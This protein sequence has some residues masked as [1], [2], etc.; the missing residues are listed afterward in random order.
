MEKPHSK[1][2]RSQKECSLTSAIPSIVDSENKSPIFNLE[3]INYLQYSIVDL[4]NNFPGGA[5]VKETKNFTYILCNDIH[6]YFHGFKSKSE[7]IGKTVFDLSKNTNPLP[8]NFTNEIQKVDEL[9]A[10]EK[11]P[12]IITNKIFPNILGFISI[13][14]MMKIPVLNKAANVAGVLTLSFDSTDEKNAK[15]LYELYKKNY[16]KDKI[17]NIKFLEHIGF[18][19]NNPLSDQEIECL[20]ELALHRTFKAAANVIGISVKTIETYLYRILHKTNYKNIS[21]VIEAF[22]KT[23]NTNRIPI[24][25]KM[26]NNQ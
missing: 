5:H 24:F 8:K 25:N 4:I 7:M 13:Q 9:V 11:K 1:K 10:I 17:K 18:E 22:I 26:R 23:S 3:Q 6:A 14:K 2:C 20:L 15:E 21:Q 16:K 19:T 12:I